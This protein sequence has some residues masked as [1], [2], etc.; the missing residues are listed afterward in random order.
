MVD[1]SEIDFDSSLGSTPTTE[2]KLIFFS[3]NWPKIELLVEQSQKT[4][5][6]VDKLDTYI[7]SIKEDMQSIK[8]I[9]LFVAG[10]SVAVISALMLTLGYFLL[11]DNSFLTEN[12]SYAGTAYVIAS[13]SASVVLLVGLIRGSFKSIRDRHKDEQL[14]PH[15]V[16]IIDAMVKNLSDGG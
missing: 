9:R 12:K 2:E 1:D 16:Q 10:F 6:L 8:R 15:V 4:K 5:D 13:I 11:C 7:D 14:P 3:D